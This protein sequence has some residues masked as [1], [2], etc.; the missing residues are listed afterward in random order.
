MARQSSD[1][2]P[3]APFEWMLALR[4]LRAKRAES[5]ISVI[6]AISLVGIA[7]GVATLIIVMAVMNGFRH[8]LL[9]RVLGLQGHVVV[10][11]ID[12]NLPNFDS[13]AD[14]VRKVAGVTLVA[15]IVDGQA[16]ASSDS[17]NTPV[18]VRGMR[19][20]DLKAFT[21]VS[22]TLSPGALAHY[23]DGDSVIIGARVAQK[24]RVVPG[25][26][27]TLLAPHGNITPFGI[28]PRVK[29]YTVA[30]TFDVGM[31]EYDQ[32]F[33]FM[34]LSEAQLYFN[35]AN[36][37]TGLEVMVRDPDQVDGMVAPIGRAAGP[38]ARIVTWKDINSTFFGAIETERNVM[39]LILTLIILVAALNIVSGLYMLVKDKSSDIA[40]LRTMGAT[41]GA[42][43]RVFLIAGVSVGVIGTFLGFLIGVVFC[44]NIESIRQFL[45]S[46]TGTTLF[47]PTIYFLSKMPAEMD[48]MEVTAVVMMSLVLTFLAT[49]YPSWRAARLDP[50]EALRYE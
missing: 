28:T 23:S 43:M 17:I 20:R 47:D 8:E 16:V 18:Y 34:P 30:G 42:I 22:K 33:V 15:P 40:I 9:S 32:T 29:T 25:M 44:D 7:L 31:S 19:L 5:F 24:L 2:R 11:G 48:P 39:F 50:V 45:S 35:M 41:R 37:V 4:Y 13:V 3:F 27:V 14:H 12:G 21:I 6:S 36:T 26:S 38:Y 1:T 10:Q 46:L 49:L